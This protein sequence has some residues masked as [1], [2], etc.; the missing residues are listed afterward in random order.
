MGT[1]CDSLCLLQSQELLA[2]F[3]QDEVVVAA[4]TLVR[5]S[6]QDDDSS[7]GRVLRYFKILHGELEPAHQKQPQGE[8]VSH[9]H[10][11]HVFDATDFGPVS[12]QRGNE[13]RHSIIDV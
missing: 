11:S 2:V 6:V 1:I 7:I 13:C 10:H 9:H 8:P 4:G 12:K 3:M 5:H